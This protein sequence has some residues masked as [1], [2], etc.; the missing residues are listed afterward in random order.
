MHMHMCYHHRMQRITTNVEPGV[1]SRLED[2]ARRR[3]VPTSHL[4]REALERY[5]TETEAAQEPEPLPDWV[6]MLDGPGGPYASR[7]EEL[8][9][10]TWESAIVPDGT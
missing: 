3:A 4:V 6:G 8:L 5:V 9:A 2:I 1:Y 10:E 7:D